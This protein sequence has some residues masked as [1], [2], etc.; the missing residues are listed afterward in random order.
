[1]GCDAIEERLL[2]LLYEE[3]PQHEAAEVRQHVDTCEACRRS[4][5][6]LS[7]AKR[8]ATH[9]PLEDAPRSLDAKIMAAARAKVGAP[10]AAPRAEDDGFFAKI[11][12]FLSSFALGPQVAMAM[13]M[14]LVVAIGVWYV[15]RIDESGGSGTVMVDPLNE[16]APS[17]VQPAPG[18]DIALDPH[19]RRIRPRDEIEAQQQA[20]LERMAERQANEAALRA[21]DGD[22]SVVPAN[23][24]AEGGDPATIVAED[25]SADDLGTDRGPQGAA[26]GGGEGASGG[27][28]FGDGL[29]MDTNQRP[30]AHAVGGMGSGAS[31]TPQGVRDRAAGQI[32]NETTAG[33]SVRAQPEADLEIGRLDQASPSDPVA[34]TPMPATSRNNVASRGGALT[35]D[36]LADDAVDAPPAEPPRAEATP[37][38]APQQQAAPRRRAPRESRAADNAGAARSVEANAERQESTTSSLLAAARASRNSGDCATA[39]NQ[40]R[41]FLGRNPSSPQR[42]QAMIEAAECYQRLGRVAEADSLLERAETIPAVAARARRARSTTVRATTQSATTADEAAQ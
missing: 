35:N 25:E 41:L 3:L 12:Q 24:L 9:L 10:Q 8:L 18:L 6:R 40:Y 5:A 33:P 13:V 23:E 7:V 34:P 16:A 36:M 21:A 20:V 15:P 28:A 4:F 17:G 38:T 11:G 37:T 42:G 1:M 30:S 14:L 29:A 39:I 32:E 27:Y 31:A 2:D 19:T 26:T 22:E